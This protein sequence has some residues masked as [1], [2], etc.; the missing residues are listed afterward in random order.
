MRRANRCSHDPRPVGS[1]WPV[2][3]LFLLRHSRQPIGGRWGYLKGKR[4]IGWVESPTHVG[5]S[6]GLRL[7]LYHGHDRSAHFDVGLQWVT[8]FRSKIDS[9]GRVVM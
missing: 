7:W 1:T 4:T 2:W 5:H 3:R 6:V 8:K 9:C